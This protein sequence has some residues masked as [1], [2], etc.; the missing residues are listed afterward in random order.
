MDKEY[1]QHVYDALNES[2]KAIYNHAIESFTAPS[3]V[4]WVSDIRHILMHIYWHET[5]DTLSN[6]GRLFHRNHATVLYSIRSV[7]DMCKIDSVYAQIY[8][9]LYDNYKDRL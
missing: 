9:Q 1:N 8:N 5:R 6:I 4:R 3:R 2:V 7:E